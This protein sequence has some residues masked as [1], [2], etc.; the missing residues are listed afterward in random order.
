MKFRNGRAG[1]F[2][3]VVLRSKEIHRKKI[4]YPKFTQRRSP[5]TLSQIL[6]KLVSIH[7]RNLISMEFEK[8]FIRQFSG[9]AQIFES[10][11][12]KR[13]ENL[14]GAKFLNLRV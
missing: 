14:Q 3:E 8:Y 13:T 12:E 9:L 5:S 10:K 1:V 6:T 4:I 2:Y 7:R 11:E